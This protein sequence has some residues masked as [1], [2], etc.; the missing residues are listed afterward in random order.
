MME[1]RMMRDKKKFP[2]HLDDAVCRCISVLTNST[3]QITGGCRNP[4]NPA[5]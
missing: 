5:V 4:L 2:E 3:I 1:R